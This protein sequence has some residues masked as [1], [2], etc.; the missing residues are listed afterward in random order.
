MQETTMSPLLSQEIMALLAK[1]TGLLDVI[2]GLATLALGSSHGDCAFNPA[3]APDSFN[4]CST[5]QDLRHS[6]ALYEKCCQSNPLI[7]NIVVFYSVFSSGHCLEKTSEKERCAALKEIFLLDTPY[8]DAEINAVHASLR[9]RLAEARV[10][11]T[12]RGYV[13]LATDSFFPASYGAA[14]RA[15]S[16]LKHHHR[17]NEDIH[18]VRLLLAAH[19]RG[20]RVFIVIPPARADYRTA[21]GLSSQQLFASL[22]HIA[23]F[24]FGFDVNVINL[25]DD[26]TFMDAHFG[27]FD[28]LLPHGGGGALLTQLVQRHID[29]AAALSAAR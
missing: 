12:L 18:L 6:Y 17:K 23:G 16:H 14:R 8:D 20:Q 26:Y 7:K 25:F 21:L 27:D 13:R 5:S 9:G 3:Y 11:N 2:G 19:A 28:H 22:F 24:K 10:E 4:L 15:E 1:R 29:G